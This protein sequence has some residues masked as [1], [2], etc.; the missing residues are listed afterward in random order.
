MT[1]TA[2]ESGSTA[3]SSRFARL[4][5]VH[6]ARARAFFLGTAVLTLAI[7][8]G[9]RALSEIQ[10]A[11]LTSIF[12]LL[13]VI[14]DHTAALCALLILVASALVPAGGQIH[15]VP[16]WMGKHAALVAGATVALL[17][18]GTVTI[19]RNHPLSMDE[20]APFFQSR[21]FA[22]GRLAGYFPPPLIDWLVPEYFQNFFI[23][24]SET[25]GAV[26]S[27]YWPAF[28]LLLTPLTVL[29]I[30]WALNPL[31][32]GAS[33]LAI[34]RL[35]LRL[36]DDQETAGL[37]LLFTLSSPVFLADGI[38]YYSMSAHLLANCIFALLVLTPTTRRLALAGVVGSIALT[39][40]NPLPHLLFA[41]PWALWLLSRRKGM[42]ALLPLAAG[43]LPLSIVLG[44]GWPW[45]SGSIFHDGLVSA[46]AQSVADHARSAF[47]L[48][49][50]SLLL[51]RAIGLA[52][53]WL[54]AA[55]GLVL[56]ACAG[57]WKYRND[58][59]CRVLVAC[60]LTTLAGFLF[61]PFDQGHGWGFRYFHSA[62]LVLPILGAAA[63]SSPANNPAA[64]GTYGDARAF[65][66]N[67][68]LLALVFGNGLRIVQIGNFVGAHLAQLPK[69][70]A[71]GCQVVIIDPQFS[72]YAQ[73][74]VQNDPLLRDPI[75]RMVSHGRA[76]DERMMGRYF[77]A[78]RRIS[79]DSLGAVWSDSSRTAPCLPR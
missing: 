63:L 72:F 51:A 62:W 59:R 7:L 26:A 13:F 36:F 46:A 21:I 68:A 14:D 3:L 2:T 54:W 78:Y 32:G 66:I 75:I 70:I 28:A 48:P 9:N 27:S 5:V 60:A 58:A 18:L 53:V 4:P 20:Y 1:T 64:A 71:T 77:P 22:A 24:V 30:P 55:P 57:I 79:A 34:H 74:A 17:A 49:D 69:A 16:R 42:R 10:P 65:F 12:F 15:A 8:C 40:H 44:I 38:S 43:Y 47:A 45:F 37:A 67:A 6:S 11:G 56:L 73:D 19:Y 33:L 23:N 76:A 52:K 31:I 35:T 29:G 50:V 41:L 25:N 39:L 61:V